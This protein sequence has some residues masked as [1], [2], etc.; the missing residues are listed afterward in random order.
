MSEMMYREESMGNPG[1]SK[2]AASKDWPCRLHSMFKLSLSRLTQSNI[3]PMSTLLS[4]LRGH[5]FSR[6]YCCLP[7]SHWVA[8]TALSTSWTELVFQLS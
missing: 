2:G 6:N 4:N 1:K 8:T 5:C 7:G 3:E